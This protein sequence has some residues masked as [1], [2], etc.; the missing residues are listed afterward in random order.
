ME[1]IE[2]RL[3]KMISRKYGSLK[4]FSAAIEIPYPTLDSIFKRGLQKSSSV[5]LVKIC[6]ALNISVTE[7]LLNDEIVGYFTPNETVKSS[8]Y[9]EY[10]VDCA[11]ITRVRKERLESAI[12][13]LKKEIEFNDK[14][15]IFTHV[16]EE[17]LLFYYWNLNDKGKQEANKRLIEMTYVPEYQSE[18]FKK[19]LEENESKIEINQAAY[20][21]LNPHKNVTEEQKKLAEENGVVLPEWE[22]AGR[23]I[24]KEP[25]GSE[26]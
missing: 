26:Q 16:P 12:S 25:E 3:K 9:Q 8:W 4:N 11:K 17:D 19:E 20:D 7:L 1:K 24:G 13:Y 2:T 10:L 18:E 6:S 23:G 15:D 22:D 5:N 14:N 21:S